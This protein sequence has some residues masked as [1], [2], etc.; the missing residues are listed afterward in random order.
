M[1]YIHIEHAG[2]T[3]TENGKEFTA[4]S[5]VNLDIEKGEFICLLGPSGC[6]KSTLLNAIAGFDLAN[7]GS[8]QI[9][10]KEVTS[11]STKNVTIFQNYGLLP[12]RTVIKNIEL[13]LESKGIDKDK[14]REIANKYLKLVKLEN[15]AHSFP[16][17]LSGGMKQRV[18][19]ARALAVEPDI[20]FMD[21]P[22]GALDA[23]TRM[24]LQDDILDICKNEKKTIIFVTHDIEE[25]VFLA[26]RI[27]VMTP[28]P[29][30]VKG[31]I[32]VPL[33]HFRDR[34][35]GDFL[36]VRDKIFDLLNMKTEEN[37]EYNI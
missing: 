18:A 16:R 26:D 22:F 30:K 8:V 34:T 28:N 17:Q 14:R 19:I 20:I 6:G 13:G 29:G 36:L 12:W 31:V 2:K 10:G 33:H 15:F 32:K 35:S 9:D 7:K 1:S 23:I 25:A 11:P 3:F 21:E 4:L 27:V 5:D 37:I 24:K